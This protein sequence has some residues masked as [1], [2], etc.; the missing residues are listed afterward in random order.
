LKDVRGQGL[1]LGLKMR[2]P[3][4]DVLKIGFEALGEALQLAGDKAVGADRR[5]PC[6]RRGDDK[7]L[8][9]G[10][11]TAG[12]PGIDKAAGARRVMRTGA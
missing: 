1:M 7:R 8:R 3:A 4:S 9:V 11:E 2:V 10:V 5:D 6:G 12:V